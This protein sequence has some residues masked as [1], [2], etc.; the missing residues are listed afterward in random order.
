MTI[1]IWMLL[2]G[3]FA[4]LDRFGSQVGG[5]RTVAKRSAGGHVWSAVALGLG[6]ASA[7]YGAWRT[8]SLLLDLGRYAPLHVATGLIV[9]LTQLGL[10][11]VVVLNGVRRVRGRA[12]L[13]HSGQLI[14][15]IAALM[16]GAWLVVA[17]AVLV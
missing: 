5:G 3:V 13:M 9:S 14:L 15:G 7:C 6:G 16:A 4:L 12:P 8:L 17:Y 11:V 2:L 1:A 10:G